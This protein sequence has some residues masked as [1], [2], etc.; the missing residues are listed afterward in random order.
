M[1]TILIVDDEVNLNNT[2]KITLSLLGDFNVEQAFTGNDGV[3]KAADVQPNL[4]IMD[5]KMPDISGW[6]ASRL[7]RA[8]ESTKTIPIIG[9]TAWASLDDIKEGI[10]IGLNEII[11]KP[12]DI[13]SWQEKLAKY[14]TE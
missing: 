1:K 7:I 4:I 10:K 9:Y 2:L 12:F 6:E 13:D 3:A 11:T 8:N 14:L 5:Y